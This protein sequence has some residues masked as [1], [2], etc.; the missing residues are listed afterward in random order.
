MKLVR[1][2]KDGKISYGVLEENNIKVIN[3]D[4][5]DKFTVTDNVYT[6]N[7]VTLKAPC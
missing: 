1:F 4:I 6:L 2:Q 5:F 3:G 7:E